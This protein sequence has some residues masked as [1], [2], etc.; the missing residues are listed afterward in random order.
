MTQQL[1]WPDRERVVEYVHN[2]PGL[3]MDALDGILSQEQAGQMYA[4]LFPPRTDTQKVA[5]LKAIRR[6]LRHSDYAEHEVPLAW[7]ESE[8]AT[9]TQA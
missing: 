8:L 6:E 4:A 3:L 5:A 2:N 9:L 1:T 7:I